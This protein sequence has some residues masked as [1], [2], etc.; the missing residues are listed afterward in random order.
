MALGQILMQTALWLVKAVAIMALI[1]LIFYYASYAVRAYNTG[2]FQYEMP[3]I[4]PD[5]ARLALGEDAFP[6]RIH[7]DE[8]CDNVDVL[9]PPV[10]A[11]LHLGTLPADFEFDDWSKALFATV[12]AVIFE[13]HE[14][15][16]HE[17][18]MTAGIVKL[19]NDTEYATIKPNYAGVVTIVQP[20]DLGLFKVRDRYY[21]EGLVLPNGQLEILR[22]TRRLRSRLLV[23]LTTPKDKYFPL[24]YLINPPSVSLFCRSSTAGAKSQIYP[25]AWGIPQLSYFN[26]RFWGAEPAHS[27]LWNTSSR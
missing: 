1:I 7:D 9:L 3:F 27:N 26:G 16:L 13:D 2:Y 22:R 5:K 21:L 11:V 10:D 4:S 15:I 12:T 14:G 18:D 6:N 20:W 24:I 17:Y 8:F 25:Q 23:G 19:S